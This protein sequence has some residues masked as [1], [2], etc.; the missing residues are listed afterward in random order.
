MEN[1]GLNT[2]IQPGRNPWSREP[3]RVRETI[4][5]DDEVVTIQRG[6]LDLT[7]STAGQLGVPTDVQGW[8]KDYLKGQSAELIA[9]GRHVNFRNRGAAFVVRFSGELARAYTKV[10]PVVGW[11]S[12]G[13]DTAFTLY[14][15]TRATVELL[16]GVREAREVQSKKFTGTYAL[17][18]L[19]W[20]WATGQR[21]PNAE[22][23][24]RDRC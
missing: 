14:D 2:E 22:E 17:C 11:V 24:L 8:A 21:P 12:F 19:E 15:V 1:A 10:V 9:Y 3:K 16:E 6:F 4:S 20:G 5:D 18:E 13:A 7:K 23:I